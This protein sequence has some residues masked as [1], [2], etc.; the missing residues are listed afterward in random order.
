MAWYDEAI[1]AVKYALQESTGNILSNTFDYLNSKVTEVGGLTSETPESWNSTIFDFIGKMSENVVLPIAG[2]IIS[3]VLI[4]ELITMIMDKN[5]FHEFDTSLFIRYIIKACIAVVIVAHTAEIVEAIFELGGQIA[6]DATAEITESTDLSLGNSLKDLLE[7][8]WDDM[9]LMDLFGCFC[10]SLVVWIAVMGMGIYIAII[11]YGRFMEI[12]LYT[13]V[14]PIPFATMSNREWGSI[15]TNYLKGIIAL[16]FQGF[17]I[18][19]CIGIYATLISGLAGTV[20]GSEFRDALFEVLI[21][22][23]LLAVSI[24][25]TGSLSKS[26]FGT[27]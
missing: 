25:K 3:Y 24:G 23:I 22:T 10:M 20:S 15:G 13:S 5:N 8:Q 7:D 16:A 26:I 21:Y 2:I 1:D 11:M 6:A 19:V 12:Y 17:L 18:M 14:A 27:H 4:Y 9:T